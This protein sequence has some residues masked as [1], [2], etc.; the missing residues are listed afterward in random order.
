[1]DKIR[2]NPVLLIGSILSLI[3]GLMLLVS[4]Y[5]QVIN[6][7]YFAV[8]F[9]LIITGVSKI[10]I[11]NNTHDKS[12]FYDG[13]VDI[14]VGILIMFVHNL[15][16]TIILGALFI[17]FPLIRI[18][19]SSSR[20]QA[21]KKE[22]PLLIIGLVIALSGDLIAEIFIKGLGILF[23]LFAIYL[24][25]CIFYDKIR[26]YYVKYHSEE[27]NDKENVIDVDYEE[28]WL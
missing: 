1:M 5:T 28:S 21:F 12:Y 4:D 26:F 11:N 19:K 27:E 16:V 18:Y 14:V 13:V 10:I 20:K 7:I 2:Q 25:I 17:V 3:A 6:F 23:I 24:F 9:G 22:L 15:I 8:G